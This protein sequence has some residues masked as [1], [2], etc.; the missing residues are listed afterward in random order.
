MAS[1]QRRPQQPRTMPKAQLIN[2]LN[3]E[4]P[5]TARPDRETRAY[6]AMEDDEEEDPE[7]EQVEERTSHGASSSSWQEG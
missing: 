1:I 2:A 7:E 4:D 5:T 3:L 6:T